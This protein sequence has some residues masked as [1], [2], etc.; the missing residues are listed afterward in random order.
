MLTLTSL[1]GDDAG[2]L[3]V[4]MPDRLSTTVAHRVLE[5]LDGGHVKTVGVLGNM[6][7]TTARKR[8]ASGGPRRLAKEF[9][10]PL[11]GLL[12]YDLTVAAAV[13]KGSIEGLLRTEFARNLRMSM[14]PY[15]R[16]L[17]RGARRARA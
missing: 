15:L 12:P 8:R 1:R 6:V 9:G 3:V 13:E 2:A 14:A 4:T 7:H 16:G 5:L 17:G 10:V 11:L